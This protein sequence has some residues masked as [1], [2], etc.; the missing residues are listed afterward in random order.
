MGAKIM[1]KVGNNVQK[2]QK[3]CFFLKLISI[4]HKCLSSSYLYVLGCFSVIF[5][6]RLNL[7]GRWKDGDG[8]V[9]PKSS[10]IKYFVKR[11]SEIFGYRDSDCVVF[12]FVF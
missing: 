12:N 11:I 8:V 5:C 4:D 7:R 9:V 1:K 6:A 3:T 10:Q 2:H